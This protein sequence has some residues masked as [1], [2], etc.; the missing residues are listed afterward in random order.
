MRRNGRSLPEI[1]HAELG[2]ITGLATAV[3]VLFIVVVAL[4]GLG[5]AVVNALYEN[6]WG[7]FT[8]V[9]TIP[10]AF[11]MGL[12]LQKLRPG[13]VGEMTLIGLVLLVFTII[14]GRIC[15]PFGMG[16]LVFVGPHHAD[17]VPRSLWVYGV[18][19]PR[20]D[21]LGPSRLLV[22]LYEIGCDCLAR[23]RSHPVSPHH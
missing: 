20:L 13:Q 21:P 10:I 22:H 12:Y 7:T 4:A 5:L 19:P 1:A 15:R 3:A 18:R 23:S 9:M 8:I 11:I 2:P 14:F 17:L 6:A 16:R